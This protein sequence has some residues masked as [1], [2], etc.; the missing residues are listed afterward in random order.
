MEFLL[1]FQSLPAGWEKVDSK[2]GNLTR[3]A[4]CVLL[5]KNGRA[6]VSVDGCG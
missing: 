4:L 5:N 1:W 6:Q 3:C 2:T